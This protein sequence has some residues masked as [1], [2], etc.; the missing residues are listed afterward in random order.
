MIGAGQPG[1][2]RMAGRAGVIRWR[3]RGG[4]TIRQAAG[5]STFID[6]FGA[7]YVQLARSRCRAVP[8]RHHVRFDAVAEHGVKAEGNAA[9]ASASTRQTGRADRGRP[10]GVP[11]ARTRSPWSE[12]TGGWR[13]AISAGRSSSV[14]N[15]VF[16]GGVQNRCSKG[17]APSSSVV[18]W[19]RC[20]RCS[21]SARGALPRHPLPLHI[22]RSG[23]GSSSG[24]CSTGGPRRFGV[25]AGQGTRDRHRRRALALRDRLHRHPAPGGPARAAGSTSSPAPGGSDCSTRRDAAVPQGE[26][27]LLE[28]PRP[29]GG[30]RPGDP[31]AFRDTSTR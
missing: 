20:C 15:A 17:G 8:G 4:A 26:V 1:E 2:P 13:A 30:R 5:R 11:S 14:L 27:E 10:A 21:G 25:I 7:D 19:A 31:G 3:R 9:G 18:L 29:G 28:E 6:T 12:P 16:K 22:S 24:T 23:T